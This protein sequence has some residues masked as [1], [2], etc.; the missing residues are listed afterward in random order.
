MAIT[1]GTDTYISVEDARTY[2]VANDL[3]LP[4][5][6][7]DLE[8]LL[9]R[10]T[11]ALDRRFGARYIGTKHTHDQPLAWPRDVSLVGT[12]RGTGESWNYTVDSD[13]NPR[14]FGSTIPVEMAEGTVEMAVCIDENK[15]PLEPNLAPYKSKEVT[16]GDL[17]SK[18]EYASAQAPLS[19]FNT[20]YVVL[21]PLLKK[22][23]G[24]AMTRGA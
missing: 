7:A 19:S 14:V 21:R 15:N 22:N 1:V 24:I 23:T 17:S 4:S 13:G 10:A 11:K 6:D 3:E 12:Y 18:Y 2:A 16:L 9:K 8:L 20:V 5:E